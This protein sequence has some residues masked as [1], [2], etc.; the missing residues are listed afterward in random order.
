MMQIRCTTG[1]NVFSLLLSNLH[2]SIARAF[3][4]HCLERAGIFLE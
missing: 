3:S 4:K 1:A 2:E